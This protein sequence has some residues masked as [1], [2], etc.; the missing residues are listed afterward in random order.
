MLRIGTW[1]SA[2]TID[3]VACGWRDSSPGPAEPGIKLIFSTGGRLPDLPGLR[4]GTRVA[5]GAEEIAGQLLRGMDVVLIEPGSC[6]AAP[7]MAAGMWHYGWTGADLG[8]LA[9]AAV[10]GL[11]LAAQPGPCA[12]EIGRDGRGPRRARVGGGGAGGARRPLL[13]RPLPHAAGDG[14]AGVGPAQPGGPEPGA[15]RSLRRRPVGRGDGRPVV[16]HGSARPRH[17]IASP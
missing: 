13:R 15:H 9:G 5:R 1:R 10:A 7:V 3:L 6:P 11:A 8:A 16:R 12:V 4:A 17:G 14:A 2:D